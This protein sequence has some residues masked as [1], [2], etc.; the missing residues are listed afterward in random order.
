MHTVYCKIQALYKSFIAP[1]VLDNNTVTNFPGSEFQEHL[2][3]C[4][5]HA[6][7]TIHQ[8]NAAKKVMYNYIVSVGKALERRFPDME[9]IIGNTAF[10]DPSLW[11]LQQPNMQAIIDKFH[12]D[13][14]ISAAV[15]NSQHR[16]YVNDTAIDFQYEL[17]GKDHVKFWCQLYKEEDYKELSSFTC[18]QT[19]GDFSNF[20]H[21]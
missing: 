16:L 12:T 8:L 10:L 17:T 13:T 21:L 19:T 5:N 7:L 3:D 2:S 9:F 11:M 15:L 6:L 18:T 1:V 20:G 4:E 14:Q